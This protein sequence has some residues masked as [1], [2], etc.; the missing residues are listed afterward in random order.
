[1]EK[2]IH[3][4]DR[5]YK[6]GGDPSC[7]RDAWGLPCWRSAW[8][9]ERSPRRRAIPIEA[10]LTITFT[11]PS[12]ITPP[13]P[14]VPPNPIFQDLTG[15]AFFLLP[16]TS[17]ELGPVLSVV[18]EFPIGTL[19]AGQSFV[20][21][22]LPVDPCVGGG[23]CQLSFSFVGASS[24][25]PA[26]AFLQGDT[27]P[28][29][30]PEGPPILPLG[31]FDPLNPAP[32]RSRVRSWPLTTRWWSANGRVSLHA[33]AAVPLHPSLWVAPAWLAFFGWLA[34]V[35]RRTSAARA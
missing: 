4:D 28:N 29:A 33:V 32:R 9:R 34:F 27:L 10:D 1:V 31:L 23:T 3:M 30:T 24:S 20:T 22:F 8:P 7:R 13:N 19:A 21:T 25:F 35:R 14:I 18:G 17:V 6:T 5:V 16:V 11:P 2:V 12:P 26:F 15:T